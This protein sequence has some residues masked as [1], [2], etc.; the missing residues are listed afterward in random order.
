MR[1]PTRGE[2]F[3]IGYTILLIFAILVAHYAPAIRGAG[4]AVYVNPYSFIMD[5]RRLTT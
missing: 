4:E 3:I 1:K 2:F 5:V